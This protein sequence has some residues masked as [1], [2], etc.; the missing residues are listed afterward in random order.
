LPFSINQDWLVDS[1][2]QALAAVLHGASVDSA[3][4][5]LGF[6]VVFDVG[7]VVFVVVLVLVVLLVLCAAELVAVCDVG[8]TVVGMVVAVVLSCVIGT[9]CATGCGWDE[10]A[11]STAVAAST[12]PMTSLRTCM[13]TPRPVRHPFAWKDDP[14]LPEVA[15]WQV[16]TR[17]R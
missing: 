2:M 12:A 1:L 5:G 11:L 3:G 7:V 14:T 6:G 9:C 16:S 4:L 8:L 10:Q 15:F 13:V 17:S